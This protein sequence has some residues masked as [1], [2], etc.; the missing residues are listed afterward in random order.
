MQLC[1]K[2]THVQMEGLSTHRLSSNEG[3][4]HIYLFCD[5]INFLKL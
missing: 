5:L 2:I 4:Q 3:N 1:V